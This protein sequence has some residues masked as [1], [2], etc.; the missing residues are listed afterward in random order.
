MHNESS[1]GVSFR[2]FPSV[3]R[4]CG[5]IP[6]SFFYG[7]RDEM[8]CRISWARRNCKNAREDD[9]YWNQGE[10]KI[11]SI[12]SANNWEDRNDSFGPCNDQNKACMLANGSRTYLVAMKFHSMVEPL[13]DA[14]VS[15]RNTFNGRA[16]C[17][18]VHFQKMSFESST[19]LHSKHLRIIENE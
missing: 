19:N 10:T 17:G 15:R 6:I 4:P 16:F 9:D 14:F 11:A 12:R 7:L 3:L 13:M 8:S 1:L 18:S 2:A 5:G